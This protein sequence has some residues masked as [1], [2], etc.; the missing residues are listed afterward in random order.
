M[1]Q[2][3]NTFVLID[4]NALIHRSFH[5]IPHLTTQDGTPINAA[6]GF[7]MTLLSAIK[8]LNPTYIAAAY[9]LPKPT[10]RHQEYKEY[11]AHREKPADELITQIPITKNILQSL[12]IPIYEKAGLEADDIIGIVTN[13]SKQK[14]IPVIIVTGDMDALQLVDENTNVYTLRR[15]LK[16]T[17]IYNPKLVE[18]RYGFTPEYLIDY[19]ALRGDPSDNIPGVKGIG[20]KTAT[21]LIKKFQ[22]IEKIYDFLEKDP[23]TTEIK[24]GIKKK[25][26]NDK[27]MAFLSKKL[28]TIVTDKPLP[29]FKI[30]DCVVKEYNQDN[31]IKLFQK[32]E[33]KSLI[34]RLPESTQPSPQNLFVNL[35]EKSRAGKVWPHL[36]NKDYQ[37]INTI[38]QLKK[39]IP[40]LKNGFTFDTETSGLDLYDSTKLV[41][42][43]ISIKPN[44]AFYLPLQHQT[45]DQQLPY[46]KAVQL[47]QPIFADPKIPKS[48]HH[49]KFDIQALQLAEIE[50]QG[51]AFDT[52]LASYLLNPNS[53]NTH[54]LDHLAFHRLNHHMIPITQLIGEKPKQITFDQVPIAEA[55]MYSG[56]DADISHQ[57]YLLLKKEIVQKNLTEILNKIELPLIEVLAKIENNGFLLDKKYFTLFN[58]QITKDIKKIEKKIHQLAGEKFNIASTQQL[59]K[60][61]YTQLK[62]PTDHITKTKTGLSTAANELAKLENEHPIIPLIQQYR[63]LTKLKNTYVDTLPKLAKSDNRIHANF[64]QTITA[65][66]RLSSSNPNLQNIPIK[67]DIGRQIRQGFIAPPKHIIIAADYSQIELRIMAH[68]AQEPNMITAFQNHQD[69]HRSTAAIIYNCPL[70]KVTDKQRYNAKTINFSIIYGAGPRNIAGQLGIKFNDARQFIDDYFHKFPHIKKYMDDAINFTRQHGYTQ[71]LYNRIRPVPDINSR[72]P[73]VRSQA[74]RMAINTPIQGTAADIMKIAMIKMFNALIPHQT[75]IISQVH[76]ELIFE[77]PTKESDQIIPLIKTTMESVAQLKVPLIVDVESGSNWGNMQSINL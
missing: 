7:T 6:Y 40:Q 68:V 38:K 31:A 52:M 71:T 9:D 75:K 60:I 49:L 8:E 58:R 57:L 61:L 77:C 69:I 65:T 54:N 4:A 36:K 30:E 34:N 5:A 18:Q 67:S 28:A 45:K 16:D 46:Q 73:Q 27:K 37:N 12:N 56:E 2:P 55:T 74:E 48:G 21:E 10:F 23:N 44:Q 51:I 53:P 72:N 15:G 26:V 59:A 33:F 39:L 1:P 25:L 24:P 3:K 14:N 50:T 19:K 43:S 64:N 62:L 13:L 20:D 32:L 66:G 29:K 17:I 41:G 76:D 11:K 63:L 35:P 22:T 47:L 70:D 42:I